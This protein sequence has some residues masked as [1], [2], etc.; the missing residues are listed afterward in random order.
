MNISL[1][2]RPLVLAFLL[3]TLSGVTVVHAETTITIRENDTLSGIVQNAYPQFRNRNAIMQWILQRNPQAFLDG[4]IDFLIL[5][6]E[7]QLPGAEELAELDLSPVQQ[8]PQVEQAVPDPE[9]ARR[10]QR[11]TGERDELR[12]QLQQ[13]ETDNQSLRADITRLEQLKGRQDAQINRL[14]QQLETLQ[15]TVNQQQAQQ[16]AAEVQAKGADAN[17]ASA[18]LTQTKAQ[19]TQL[20]SRFDESEQRRQQLQTLIDETEQQRQQLQARLD[21]SEQQ[22]QELQTQLTELRQIQVGQAADTESATSESGAAQQETD[23]LKSAISTLEADKK[24]LQEQI[25][26]LNAAQKRLQAEK[27]KQEA[28]RASLKQ[29]L[30]ELKSNSEV[31]ITA[32]A[33]LQEQVRQ[34]QQDGDI[35]RAD[36]EQLVADLQA[37]KDQLVIG[38][39]DLETLRTELDALDKKNIALQTEID[40]IKAAAEKDLALA[41]AEAPERP[42]SLWPWLMMLL[43]LPVAWFLGQR[44]RPAPVATSST[45][46]VSTADTT[47]KLPDPMVPAPLSG[48]ELEGSGFGS[49]AAVIPDDPDVAIKLDM[50]RAY[51]DLRDAEAANDVLQEVIREGGSA[52]QQEAKEI[53]SF[54]S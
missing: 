16:P 25:T 17:E 21:E 44:S 37:A 51:L 54:I 45:A 50:A 31:Q 53:L 38:E 11:I 4:N 41:P 28:E 43:L 8:V 30:D 35:L 19:L 27:D 12:A 23:T 14:E 32:N 52:Q 20:Q 34:L 18:A 24:T 3:T 46:L 29:Q 9:L 13:L 7:L 5:G 33:E 40:Q 26:E 42:A 15:T 48:E 49:N 39:T 36:N 22:K 1:R 6:R 10:L 2:F 47:N